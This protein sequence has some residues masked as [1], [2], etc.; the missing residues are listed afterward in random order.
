M[1]TESL[2]LFV[3]VA[4]RLSFAAVAAER[5]TNPSS[6]SRTISG[7]EDELGARL[8]HR[9]TRKMTLTEAGMTFLQR[10]SAI[11]DDLDQAKDEA[12]RSASD[13]RGR[14]RL[15]TSVA[16]GERVL[17]PLLKRFRN[18]F[19]GIQLDLILTDSNVD[20]AGEGIDLAIRLAASVEGDH[21][22]SKLRTTRYRVCASPDYISRAPRL[23]GP[24]GLSDHSCLLYT[25]PAFRSHWQFRDRSGRQQSVPVT[26]T[27]A[28]S[29]ALS[30]R[31]ATL[32]GCGPA[33]LADW[34][35]DDDLGT[36][37]LVD[38]FPKHEVTA[39]TYDTAAWLVY[40]NR[41]YLPQKVRVTIDF[42]RAEI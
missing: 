4:N 29:S 30:L 19:P 2:H 15:S 34:L 21:V 23:A 31:T 7:L 32:A 37:A 36:G 26:G 6:V 1:N 13:P 12:R 25:L 11:I 42:L 18:R 9:T 39:T 28:I 27:I 8:F 10:V 17:V 24:E 35:I 38:L 16:F 33:L 3:D 5:G 41:T 14:L 22:V 40:P 20:L